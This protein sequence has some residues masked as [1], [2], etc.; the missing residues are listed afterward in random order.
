[1]TSHARRNATTLARAGR[2][3]GPRMS[4][5]DSPD[6]D[7]MITALATMIRLTS[8]NELVLLDSRSVEASLSNGRASRFHAVVLVKQDHVAR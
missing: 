4:F 5:D 2:I 6:V 3:I 1:L 7:V 8:A